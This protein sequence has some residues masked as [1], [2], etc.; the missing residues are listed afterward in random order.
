MERIAASRNRSGVTK[1]GSPT[2]SEMTPSSPA[3]RSKYLRIPLAEMRSTFEF[4]SGRRVALIS[5]RHPLRPRL[6][7]RGR[8]L[9][10]GGDAEHRRLLIRVRDDLEPDRQ[11]LRQP[12][13]D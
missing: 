7:M 2:P 9:V 4:V 12:A 5:C 10:R 8:A 11:A 13:G 1:S 6:V 3:A